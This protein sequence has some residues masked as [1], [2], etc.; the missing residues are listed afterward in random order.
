TSAYVLVLGFLVM[1]AFARFTPLKY[2]FLTG[3]HMVF[4]SLLL[5]VVLTVGFGEELGWLVVLIGALL[6]GT[7]MVVMPAFAHPWMKKITGDDTIAMGHFGTAGYIAAGAAGQLTGRRSRSTEEINFPQGLTF[8]RDSMVATAL[9]MVLIYMVFA[10]WGL[11]A[12]P[13]T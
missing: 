8:L 10:I 12:E 1:L 3:H 4:M 9:S 2:I 6:L 11:I 13:A 5:S 7:I